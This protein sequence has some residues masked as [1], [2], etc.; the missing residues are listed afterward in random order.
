[1]DALREDTEPRPPYE[2][3][4]PF[5]LP[6]PLPLAHVAEALGGLL[7]GGIVASER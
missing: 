1:M 7:V 5:T 2:N 6:A 4:F 3:A